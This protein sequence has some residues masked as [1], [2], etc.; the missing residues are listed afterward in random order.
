MLHRKAIS[1]CSFPPATLPLFQSRKGGGEVPCVGWPGSP[2]G[3]DLLPCGTL[4]EH[5]EWPWFADVQWHQGLSVNPSTHAAIAEMEA[6]PPP[7][8]E[9]I[10][11]HVPYAQ[12]FQLTKHTT[13]GLLETP[14]NIHT[15]TQT[16]TN[17]HKRTC[18]H[19]HMHIYTHTY[20]HT[21]IHT[22][23]YTHICI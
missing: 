22:Y 15:H 18:I 14:L 8:L 4:M 13:W 11:P 6:C 20:A 7:I 2:G 19:T 23:T 5:W 17:I 1:S 21:N 10:T 3:R 16:H 9:N 12:F